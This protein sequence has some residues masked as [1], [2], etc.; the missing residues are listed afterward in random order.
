[1]KE[2]TRTIQIKAYTDDEGNPVCGNSLNGSGACLL[3]DIGTSCKF[4]I[5]GWG[6]YPSS[7]CPVWHGESNGEWRSVAEKV[8]HLITKMKAKYSCGDH[9]MGEDAWADGYSPIERLDSAANELA[10]ILK[11][12][13]LPPQENRHE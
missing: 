1:M 8:K 3:N 10:L 11:L 4:S 2:T 5:R 13:P 6:I 12:L 7:S 9:P